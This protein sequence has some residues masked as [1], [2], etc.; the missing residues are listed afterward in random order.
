M[1]STLSIILTLLLAVSVTAQTVTVGSTS[2]QTW[3]GWEATFHDGLHDFPSTGQNWH[4]AALDAFVDL[5]GNRIRTEIHSGLVESSTDYVTPY[6]ADGR[7]YSTNPYYSNFVSNTIRA[8]PINDNADPNSI[9]ASG[10]K[11]AEIDKTVDSYV[12]PLKAKLAVRGETLFWVLTYVHFSTSNQLHIDTPAE[13]G[14][15]ILATWQHLNTTY[16]MVPDALEIYLEPDN[17]AALVTSAEIAAMIMAA[18]NRLVNAGFAKPYIIA[19]TTTTS[20]ATLAFYRGV[21]TANV[22]AGTYVDEVAR[23]RYGTAPDDT[24]L[25]SLRNEVEA[26]GKKSSMLETDFNGTLAN[27]HQDIEVGRVSA[28][29]GKWIIA[30][31]TATDT[32]SMYFMIN[33]GSPYGL[34]KTNHAKYAE[35]YMKYIR[36]N[37]VMKSVTN[38]SSNFR[39][40]PFVNPNGKYV[41]PI[42]ALTSGT[43]TVSGLPAGTYKR[44]RT[45]GDG[46]NAPSIYNSCESDVTIASGQNV[47]ITFSGAGVGTVY[48]INYLANSAP[49]QIMTTSLPNAV[50]MRPY[51]Q[52]LQAAGGSGG[53]V[54]SVS[55]GNLPAGLWL[56]TANG[57][58]RGR[59]RLKGTRN[60]TLTV[61]DSQ[62]T[63]ATAN[64]A[65]TVSSRLYF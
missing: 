20:P 29:N 43:V 54:W 42:R 34:T 50:C 41:V 5:G 64:Q 4:N 65:F 63:S 25:V 36:Q 21:K 15:L 28:W 59:V 27:L 49:M 23:H 40:V 17:G 8:T 60:F 31:P 12:T 18:R 14:E 22:T 39:G 35:H 52:T 62:N 53:Y 45:I 58:I 32:G 56:D 48:D 10:F 3:K 13:Y 7:D 61:Q 44:C 47:T 11:F 30:Y 24:M 9:N 38:S 26:D 19:P 57:I 33:P 1:K 16:G 2:L 37:A 6:F 51:N 55:S 46:M